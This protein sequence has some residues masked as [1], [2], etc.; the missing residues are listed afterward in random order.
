MFSVTDKPMIRNSS[1]SKITD[2]GQG[3]GCRT[4]GTR[5]EN[6]MGKDCLGTRHSLLSQISFYLFCPTSVSTL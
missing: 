3:Q 2:Y 4:Y 1:L 5:L 6:G